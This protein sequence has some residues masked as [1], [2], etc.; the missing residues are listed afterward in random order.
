MG[1][2]VIIDRDRVCKRGSGSGS[3]NDRDRRSRSR[4]IKKVRCLSLHIRYSNIII[5]IYKNIN[6]ILVSYYYIDMILY[7]SLFC[8]VFQGIARLG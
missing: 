1:R 7:L 6:N 8:N 4:S 3:E 2:I 5:L